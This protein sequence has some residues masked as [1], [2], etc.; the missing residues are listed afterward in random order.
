MRAETWT[1][2]Q[3]SYSPFVAPLADLPLAEPVLDVRTRASVGVQTV[4]EESDYTKSESRSQSP[5]PPPESE[6]DDT[7]VDERAS[8]PDLPD[9]DVP[10]APPPPVTADDGGDPV[11]DVHDPEWATPTLAVAELQEDPSSKIS[12]VPDVAHQ[13][14]P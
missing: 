7:A 10:L 5:V 4:L 11:E 3:Q 6:A 1:H 8:A 13:P 14:T 12:L 2:M 9:D